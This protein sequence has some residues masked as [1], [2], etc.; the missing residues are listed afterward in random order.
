MIQKDKT[1]IWHPFTQAKTAADTIVITHGKAASLFDATGKEYLDLISSW[2]VNLHGHSHPKIVEA[3]TRQAEKL[4]HVMFAGFTHEPAIRF[5]EQLVGLL[6]ASLN[7]VFYSDNGSTAV[8][9]AVKMALQYWHNQGNPKKRLVAFEG[10][11][12]GDTF[13]AMSLGKSSGF[14][15]PFTD[16]LFAVDF[17]SYPETWMDDSEVEA[18]ES[19]SLHQLEQLIASHGNDIAALVIEPLVQGSAGMR[20]CRPQFLEVLLERCQSNNILV[21]YDEVM[22]GF[23]RTGTLFACEQQQHTPDFI[24]LSKG[25]TGGF[26]PLAVTVTSSKVYES[27]L[28]DTFSTAFTH[29][30]SYTAN[31]LGCAAAIASLSLFVEEQTFAKMKVIELIHKERVTQLQATG[32]VTQGRMCGTIAAMDVK[33]PQTQ[34]GSGMSQQLKEAFLAQGLN[35]RPLGNVIYLMPPYCIK[36]SQLHYAYDIIQKVLTAFAPQDLAR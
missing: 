29:G 25:I 27:F 35:L 20:M 2:W 4:E 3:L 8:E 21:I 7:R 1:Y 14:Y 16:H 13:G 9:A 34:Y 31:P 28:G 30:H 26:L 12:H 11:Y 17:V 32:L 24:C 15:G 6:P 22:T 19:T 10:A 18:K 23:G 36:P 33:C 5:A